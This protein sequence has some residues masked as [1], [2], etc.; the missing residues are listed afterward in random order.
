MHSIYPYSECVSCAY[1]STLQFMGLYHII[2]SMVP[3]SVQSVPEGTKFTWENC[4]LKWCV[5]VCMCVSACVCV[6]VCV[7]VCMCVSACVCMCV[8]ACPMTVWCYSKMSWMMMMKSSTRVTTKVPNRARLQRD[9]WIGKNHCSVQKM[10]VQ[11]IVSVVLH[12]AVTHL[13]FPLQPYI[14]QQPWLSG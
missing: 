2:A 12:T 5:F 4:H 8:S 6:C 10:H 1:C 14:K 11:I 13:S 3:Y 9:S 7:C